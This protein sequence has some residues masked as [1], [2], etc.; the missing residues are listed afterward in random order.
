[1]LDSLGIADDVA[2]RLRTFPNGATAM[3]EL[4]AAT[5]ARPIGCTQLTEILHTQGVTAVGHLPPGCELATVYT[6]AVTTRAAAPDLARR[7]IA[8]LTAD[9]SGAARSRAGFA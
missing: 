1:V 5:G 8:L 4:A 3:R 7:L 2:E 9:A 6:A